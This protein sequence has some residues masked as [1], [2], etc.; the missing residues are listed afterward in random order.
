[1]D[2][3]EEWYRKM[4]Q[5]RE[6]FLRTGQVDPAVR[7]AVAE[8][9][10]RCRQLDMDM[11]SDYRLEKLDREERE[12]L[13]KQN[14]DLIRAARPVL[15]KVVRLVE[16]TQYVVTLHDQNGWIL[17]YLFAG[18]NPVFSARGFDVGSLWSEETIGTCSS[19]ICTMNDT[20]IQLIGWEHYNERMK[21]MVGTA[22]PI[23]GRDGQ[24][25]GCINMCGYY[26]N[27]SLHTLGLI[28]MAAMQIESRW[29]RERMERLAQDVFELL[30]NGIAVLDRDLRVRRSTF[31]LASI[32]GLPQKTIQTLDFGSLFKK[33][34]F[35]D[36]LK[37]SSA[38]FSYPEYELS[39]P[40]GRTVSCGVQVSPVV[41]AA[42]RE[43]TVVFLQ[44]TRTLQKLANRVS[45]NRASY[46][47][48]DIITEDRE[49]LAQIGMMKEIADTDC[50]VLIE[51]E[52]GTGKELFAH[53]LHN[54]SRRRK[55]PFIAV[56]CA[57]LPRNLVE[58]EL[59][60]Y[61]KG[62]FTG[63]RSDGSPGKFELANG[64][65][66]F[67]DE[68]GELPLEVQAS[69]LRILDNHKV[70]RIGGRTEKS[71]DVRIVAATNRKLHREVQEGNFRSDL[72]FRLNVLKFDIPPLRE[73]GRDIELLARAFLL[74]I[75]EKG[76]GRKKEMSDDFLEAAFR[77]PW[78]GNVRE[79]QNAVVRAYYACRTAKLTA[80]DLP[81]RIR[82]WNPCED[83]KPHGNASKDYYKE[84]KNQG[85]SVLAREAAAS[86]KE[87]DL[88]GI[89][90][91]AEK[92]ALISAL[93][94]SMGNVE[95]AAKI[96][97]MSRATIY[98]RMKRYGLRL[99]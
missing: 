70:M 87:E 12:K 52:S 67:L 9:W 1:M 39:L 96:L 21:E 57:S 8:S 68:V 14:E 98:R 41:S 13:L 2:R 92:E 73:R 80:A 17:D 28:K 26:K 60:G 89:L 56:N 4:E 61:E 75:N 53:S 55:G 50:C 94:T 95:E 15:T 43:E 35:E 24:V 84:K 34:D 18:D 99:R 38:A 5:C 83:G 3:G 16:G 91:E 58:S 42:G 6:R 44:E 30:P 27:G 81:V 59:F 82:S 33:E 46:S 90:A 74:Q 54:A 69:L 47:F 32:L 79:L 19:C 93:K 49:M 20:E 22:A 88:S 7:P 40:G 86:G 85:N 97:G 10:L 11:S 62:A 78:P 25:A 36:R 77:Y 29:E 23:H 51:G 66:I 31:R 64:G 45:G 71:L 63:A 76:E 72:Y 65:T 37:E 48:E